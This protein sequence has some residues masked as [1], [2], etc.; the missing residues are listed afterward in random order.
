MLPFRTSSSSSVLTWQASITRWAA[1]PELIWV[2]GQVLNTL[3]QRTLLQN[4]LNFYR[5][6]PPFL[7]P[8]LDLKKA[9]TLNWQKLIL[10][11]LEHLV[12]DLQRWVDLCSNAQELVY[13]ARINGLRKSK[14][15]LSATDTSPK[16][17]QPRFNAFLARS[18]QRCQLIFLRQVQE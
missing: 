15:K 17:M 3:P 13:V 6:Q 12:Q 2:R 4:T 18:Q 11:V 5:D 8:L 7:I 9:S 10:A 16:E 14:P 1:R